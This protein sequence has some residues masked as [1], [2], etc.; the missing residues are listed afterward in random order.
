MNFSRNT[1][2]EALQLFEGSY[3]T[4]ARFERY[5]FKFGLEKVAPPSSGSK[6]GRIN[7]LISHFIEGSSQAGPGGGNIVLET[8]ELILKSHAGTS[9]LAGAFPS[10]AHSLRLDG[11]SIND[12]GSLASILPTSTPLAPK[13][14]EVER[15]LS[16]FEFTIAE[17]HLEQAVTAH[18]RGDWAAAN[19]QMR[20]FVESLFDSF[21]EKLLPASR[22]A[23][24]H[25]RRE[26]LAKLSPPFIDPALN[27]WDFGPNGG[28]VQGFWRRLHSNGSHPGL[29]DEDDCTFRL[30]L[31]YL[32]AHMFLTRFDNRP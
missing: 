2:V 26:Q 3:W 11:Y 21:S 9:S 24:S 22:P 17:G 5:L 19:A 23:T 20:S 28:F 31:V 13:E 14:T 32:V 15:L 1:I 27:E 16:K 25:G 29:S 10:L 12:D 30:Q 4:T 7:V 6:P 8:I 18:T